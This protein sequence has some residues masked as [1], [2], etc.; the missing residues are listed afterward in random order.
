MPRP[1]QEKLPGVPKGIPE[2]EEIGIQYAAAHDERMEI[3]KTEVDLKAKAMEIMRKHSLME[4]K[5]ENLT[6]VRVPGEEK[7]RVKVTIDEEETDAA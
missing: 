4:Y 2:L 1:K 3:L 6:M 7:L 5:V